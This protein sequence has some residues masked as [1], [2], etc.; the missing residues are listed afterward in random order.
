MFD[1]RILILP[2]NEIWVNTINSYQ[3]SKV[4]ENGQFPWKQ[5]M[6]NFNS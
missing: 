2:Q 1:Y 4:D 6:E 5:T 3:L